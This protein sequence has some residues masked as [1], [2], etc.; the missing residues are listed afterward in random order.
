MKHLKTSTVPQTDAEFPVIEELLAGNERFRQNEFQEQYDRYSTIA[1]Q[2]H[3]KV[4][5]IGCSDSRIQSGHI[6]N[7]Q[8]GMLFIHRNIGNIIPV[9][10]WNF[11]SVLE[12][13]I[14]HLN[15]QDIVICG[16]SD[17]G[18]IKALDGDIDSPFIQ[19]WLNNALEAKERVDATLASPATPE[20]RKNRLRCIEQENVRL[21]IEHLQKYPLAKKALAGKKLQIHGLYYHLDTG[22]L[23]KIQ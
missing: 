6:T 18:A 10:D 17:C 15:I 14:I 21:Q 12:Y 19:V 1:R 7:A 4:L 13:A 16:H 3:P 8:P 9:Q 2:Q 11:A 23:E 22:L 20:E 5:W